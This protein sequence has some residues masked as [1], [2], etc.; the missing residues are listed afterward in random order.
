[1]AAGDCSDA[2]KSEV[3]EHVASCATCRAELAMMKDP[4]VAAETKED[5][6]R[7]AERSKEMTFKKGFRKIR[8]RW[9]VSI[10]CVL[11]ILPLSGL[12]MLGYNDSRGEGYAFSNLSDAMTVRS[13]LE[14]LRNKDYEGAFQYVD[15]EGLYEDVTTP[16]DDPEEF[17]YSNYYMAKIGGEMYFVASWRELGSYTDYSAEGKD[18]KLWADAIIENATGMNATPIPKDIFAEAA[19]LAGEGLDEEITII[20]FDSELPNTDYTYMEY[21]AL[22]GESYYMPTR[23][24]RASGPDWERSVE[25]IPEEI[26]AGLRK[27]QQDRNAENMAELD[28]YRNLGLTEFTRLLKEQFISVFE[29]LDAQGFS[30]KSY[31]I[32]TPTKSRVMFEDD[33]YLK[34]DDWIFKVDTVLTEKVESLPG[35]IFL[36]FRDGRIILSGS[37]INESMDAREIEYMY[38]IVPNPY[39]FEEQSDSMIIR[40]G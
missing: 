4:A 2:T 40:L 30:M 7:T 15:V 11:L 8:R 33:A 20:T 36:S 24:G 16:W 25:I 34:L 29:E 27:D 3:E 32:G 10:V 37:G 22:N 6:A 17:N 28:Q 12:G 5:A 18:A 38:N 14:C 35:T 31:T 23:S 26:Y 39:L 21:V 1:M 19:A 9:L 13:F